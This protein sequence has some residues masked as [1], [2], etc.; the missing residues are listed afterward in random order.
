MYH[1][2]LRPGAQRQLKKIGYADLVIGLPS[3]KNGWSAAQV[4]RVA[5]EG[6]RQY[7]PALRTVLVNADAGLEATTRRAVMAQVSDNGHNNIIVSGRYEGLL[8]WGSAI[9]ALLDAALALD[10][11]AIIILDTQTT[12]ISPEWVAGL[13]HL[14]NRGL[15]LVELTVD[16]ENG[17]AIALYQSVGFKFK[18]ATMWYEKSVD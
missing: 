11:R 2:I 15:R 16:S 7:Y 9:A 13:A 1:P 12:S 18:K 6:V 5:L 8:G 17:P 14:K 3:Y 4:A 10:A